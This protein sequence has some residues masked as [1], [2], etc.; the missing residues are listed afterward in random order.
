MSSISPLG[1]ETIWK[2]TVDKAFL[3]TSLEDLIL[4]G[5]VED[6]VRVRHCNNECRSARDIWS[7]LLL[8]ETP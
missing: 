2:E 3:E 6:T 7:N 8:W 5:F 1:Y 4:P